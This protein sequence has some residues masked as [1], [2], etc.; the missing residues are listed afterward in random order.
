M[1]RAYRPNSSSKTSLAGVGSQ[2]RTARRYVQF[3]PI[4][5]GG[6]IVVRAGPI[7]GYENPDWLVGAN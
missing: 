6:E 5:A 1:R 4:D 7:E 2:A 3:D